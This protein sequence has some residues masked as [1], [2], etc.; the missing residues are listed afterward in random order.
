MW[1]ISVVNY[2]VDTQNFNFALGKLEGTPNPTIY[3]LK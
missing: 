3:A 1:L 2:M